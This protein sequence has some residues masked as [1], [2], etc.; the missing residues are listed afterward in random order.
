MVFKG[1][2]SLRSGI[3]M[4]T[5]PFSIGWYNSRGKQM[6]TDY[7]TDATKYG[8]TADSNCGIHVHISRSIGEK[9]YNFIRDYV[10]ANK[11]LFEKIG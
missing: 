2:G 4:N 11:Q 8:A 7:V 10:C 5:Q 1:D 9:A 3:E 6:I